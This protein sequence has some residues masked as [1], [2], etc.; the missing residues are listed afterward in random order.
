M[1]YVI[2]ASALLAVI[3][4]ET[5]YLEVIPLLMGSSMSTVNL[6]EV[7]Q[8]VEQKGLRIPNLVDSLEGLGI[9]MVAFST[10]QAELAAA[11]WTITSSFGLSLGDRA[12]LAL[13]QSCNAVAITADQSWANISHVQ[14]QT[15]R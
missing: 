10:E 7:L 13:A 5:G 2:D 11:M 4:Q 1:N 6:S 14:V 8:K 3:Q 9:E 12:C 15:I